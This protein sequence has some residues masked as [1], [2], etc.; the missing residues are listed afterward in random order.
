MNEN[1]LL[2]EDEEALQMALADRLRS[3]GYGVDVA[4]DG[5]MAYQHATSKTYD[6]IILDIM[7]PG[8]NG[9]DVC[10]DTRLAGVGTPILLLTARDATED[11]V[12]G[13]KLGADDYLTKPFNMHELVARI[14]ALLRRNPIYAGTSVHVFGSV[15]IDLSSMEVTKDGNPIHLSALEFRLIRYLLR[16]PGIGLSR[17]KIL[18]EVWGHDGFTTTRTVDVHVSGLR[19]KLENDPT[20]PELIITVKGFGY[21][22][23]GQSPTR[24]FS[25]TA[26]A[27]GT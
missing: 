23:S 12:I 26:D 14:E 18:K 9:L 24:A 20:R 27:T 25:L 5:I 6:L 3:E 7:L 8:R 2:V 11:K 10:R 22:F 4:S 19:E 13:L 15:R 1:I 17:Q 21:M 16:N